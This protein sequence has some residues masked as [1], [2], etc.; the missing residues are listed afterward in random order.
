MAQRIR[1]PRPARTILFGFLLA[2]VVGTGL[3]TLPVSTRAPGGIP[4]LPALFTATSA[5]C[6]TGLSDVDVPTFWTPF[7]HVVIMALIQIGGFGVMS[8]ATILG[9]GVLKRVS[10]ERRITAAT[11][12]HSSVGHLGPLLIRVLRTGLLIEGLVMVALT[13]RFLTLG[14]PV[15]QSLWYGLFH[16]VS[17]FNNAGFSL[18]PGNM[19]LFVGD[20]FVC[21]PIMAAIVLG[22]LGFPV[23]HQLAREFR[24]PRRW[25][26]NTRMVLFG[27]V[28]LLVGSTLYITVLE[29]RNPGTLGPL[30]ASQKVLAGMFQAVVSRTAGFNSVDIGAMQDATLFGMDSLMFIG[31]GPAGTAGGIK[32]TTMLVLCFIAWT[33]IRGEAAV[34]IFGKRLSRSVHRQAITVTML[35]ALVV[36]LATLGLLLITPFTLDETLFEAVSAFGTVGLSTGITPYLHPVGQL[37]V[38]GLMIIGRLGPITVATA[39]ARPKPRRHHELPKERPIIG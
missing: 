35:A 8:L 31:G 23:L 11:E 6:V 3:L 12:A 10:L 9:F 24:W 38:I 21:L 29:W 19:T 39:L 14:L 32:I 17:A 22:G 33:E 34:N 27:T 30:P 36:A 5:L 26:M 28:V 25:S 20:W 37:I 16:A 13:L 2:L 18:F 1:G 15:G 4:L 7:G